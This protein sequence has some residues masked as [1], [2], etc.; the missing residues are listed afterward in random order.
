VTETTLLIVDDEPANLAVL[1]WVLRPHYRVR[2][3]SSGEQALRA[4]ST[5]PRPDLIL[6]DVMMP[7]MDG[8]AV[9][10]QLRADPATHDIPVIFVTALDDEISEERGLKLGAVDYIA[11]P[12]KPA[13][14]LA[15]VAT[16]LELKQ[17]RDRLTEQNAWLEAEVARR[18]AENQLIQDVSIHALG[19]LA[20]IRDTETGNHIHRTQQYV[21]ALAWELSDHPRFAAQ[22]DDHAIQLLVK[23]APLHDIGKVGIPD[24]ILLKPGPLTPEEWT[25][26][27]THARLGAEAIERAEHAAHQTADFL[28]MAKEIARWHHEKWDGSGYPDGLAGEAI[29]LSARLMAL[30]D[31]FDALIT[32][33][34]YKPAMSYSEARDIITAGRGK[35]FDPAVVD[36][37][38]SN[39][40]IF[41]SIAEACADNGEPPPAADPAQPQP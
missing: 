32:Q 7:G 35:H 13:V 3:A 18:M 41:A 11:K 33:R 25:I 1:A 20:E 30:A 26:M 34:V 19:Y 9:L 36:A 24:H 27:K 17:A 40:D 15:R 28:V 21:H 5:P 29:P 31:V 39:F 22:L 8:H 6:L 14:V 10:S 16:Q 4:I 38:L 12:I 2:A 23:S 37:F